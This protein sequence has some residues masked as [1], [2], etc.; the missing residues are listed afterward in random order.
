MSGSAVKKFCQTEVGYCVEWSKN[1]K[2]LVSSH[3]E[4]DINVFDSKTYNLIA[5]TKVEDPEFHRVYG[6]GIDDTDNALKIYAGCQDKIL[7]SYSLNGNT[8]H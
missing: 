2:Y 6:I 8:L 7:R 1:N 4:G 5:T 3:Y